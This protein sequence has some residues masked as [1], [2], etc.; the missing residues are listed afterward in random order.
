MKQIEVEK[1]I[2][3]VLCHDITQ[4]I[5]DEKKGVAFKKGHIIC[6]EDVNVLLSLGKRHLYVWESK[7]GFI[8]ENE[9]A[10]ILSDICKNDNM[11]CSDVSEGKIELSAEC[12]GLFK[13]DTEVLFKINSITDIIIATRHSNYPVKKG[14]VLIS[15]RVVPLIIEEKKMDEVKSIAGNKPMTSL[16]PY[17]KKTAGVITTGSEVYSKRIVDTFTPVIVDKIA[18]FGLSLVDH[19]IVDDDKSQIIDAIKSMREQNV[20]VIICT[21][22]MSVDP[23]DVTP[24]AIKESNANI[25]SYG[26]PVFPGS[27]LL[28]AYFD[29][30]TPILGIPG[31]T[32]Y[33]K[34]TVFDLILPFIASG[35]EITKEYL[36]RLGHG[37]LC[38]KC[39]TCKFPHCEFGK[40]A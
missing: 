11:K 40:G 13:I 33:C 22:G 2:G 27:M 8:H 39:E 4:I 6:E 7:A 10:L 38:L 19:K 30:R 16:T 1:S 14:D 12:D 29:N 25:V 26:V 28:V 31:C 21:G 37:G 18:G 17:S 32:M 15:T 5:K 34:T 24:T 35:I 36:I 23:D 9:A 20:D 3:H